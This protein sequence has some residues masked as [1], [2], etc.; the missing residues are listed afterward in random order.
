MS[1]R[2]LPPEDLGGCE[3]VAWRQVTASPRRPVAPAHPPAG[4]VEDLAQ[5]RRDWEQQIAAARQA[6]RAEGE[7]AARSQAAAEVQAALNRMAKTIEDLAGHRAQL[8]QEA[9]AD[10][11]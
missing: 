9:E 3:P 1:S 10:T 8:R 2:L 5:T 7:P 6:G 4:P 11:V